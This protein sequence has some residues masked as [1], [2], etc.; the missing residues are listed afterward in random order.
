MSRLLEVQQAVEKCEKNVG[1]DRNQNS[2]KVRDGL[3]AGRDAAD[4]ALQAVRACSACAGDYEDPDRTV[5]TEDAAEHG[6][7]MDQDDAASR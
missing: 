3:A 5:W 2:F 6:E 7:E 1:W 4:T